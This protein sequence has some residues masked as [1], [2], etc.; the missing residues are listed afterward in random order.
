MHY[1]L[2]KAIFNLL[3]YPNFNIIKGVSAMEIVGMI[4]LLGS[5]I[6]SVIFLYQLGIAYW[7]QRSLV[8][9]G[10]NL[11]VSFALLTMGITIVTATYTPDALTTVVTKRLGTKALRSAQSQSQKLQQ[12][13]ASLKSESASLKTGTDTVNSQHDALVTQSSS[14]KSSQVAASSKAAS[15]ASSISKSKARSLQSTS[16]TSSVAAQGRI[17]GNTKTKVY[18]LPGQTRYSISSAHIIYFKTE[19][20]ALAAGYH[21]SLR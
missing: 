6:S 9:I 11:L 10:N 15:I 1:P 12:Q 14:L 3:C 18:H 5:I 16:S 4:I 21:K 7:H 2:K 8:N 19:Q 13:L 20:E 17:I